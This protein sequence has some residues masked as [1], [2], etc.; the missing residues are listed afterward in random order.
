MIQNKSIGIIGCGNMG[1]ALVENLKKRADFSGI[2]IFDKDKAKQDSIAKVFQVK[3]CGS[4]KELLSLVDVVIVAVKPQDIDTVLAG[5]KDISDKLIISIAA[6]ITLA[7]LEAALGKNTAIIRAMPNLNAL[8]GQSVTALCKNDVASD[9]DLRFAEEIFRSVGEVVFI[10]ELQM[11]AFTAVA[12]SGPAFVAYLIKDLGAQALEQVMI[13]EAVNLKIEP[14][15][16]EALAKG[17]ISGTRAMLSVNFD[18]HIL[19]KRV[20]SKGGTTEAGMKVLEEKGKTVEALRAAIRAACKRAEELS[21]SA[22]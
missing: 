18:P 4:I 10:Q 12:G 5:L 14:A 21:R 15:T 2:F 17:T 8:I 9:E 1:S 6:G 20:S 3:G 19:I 11:N 7:S 16:A 13:E 22:K